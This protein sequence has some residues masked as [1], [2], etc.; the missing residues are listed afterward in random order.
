M[1]KLTK[2]Q[3]A[4][5]AKIEPGKAY[6]FVDAAALL[7]E[8]PPSSSPSPLMFPSTSALTRVNP[9]RSF[10]VPPFCLTAAAKPFA[11]LCSPRVRALKLLWLPVLTA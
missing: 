7:A 9:T 4:I 10:V 6:S 11:S 3:K 8:I 2:R 5:A 1:A